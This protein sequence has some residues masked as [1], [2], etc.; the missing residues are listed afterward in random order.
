MK[1]TLNQVLI[2]CTVLIFCFGSAFTDI[3]LKSQGDSCALPGFFEKAVFSPDGEYVLATHV[4]GPMR[5]Y[6]TKTGELVQ[7]YLT[8]QPIHFIA[9]SPDG[10]YIAA[11]LKDRAVLLDVLTGKQLMS[12]M[13]N[14]ANPYENFEPSVFF[15][16]DGRFLLTG[17]SEGAALW[18]TVGGVQIHTYSGDMR[19]NNG[20]DEISVAA[21]Y[22]ITFDAEGFLLWNILTGKLIHKF[23][24]ISGGSASLSPDGKVIIIDDQRGLTVW[25]TQT[26]SEISALDSRDV[27]SRTWFFSP[28]SQYMVVSLWDH[29]IP[30]E[31]T[32]WQISPGKRLHNFSLPNNH[33]SPVVF[34]PDSKHLYLSSS[35]QPPET[36]NLYSIDVWSIPSIQLKRQI[37]LNTGIGASSFQFSADGTQW[38]VLQ[39][40]GQL[41]LREPNTGNEIMHYC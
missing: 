12:Y 13:R 11:G 21:Q 29:V 27:A 24:S 6:K 5:L 4:P 20:R 36:S 33:V 35:E 8:D 7:T 39:G 26:Y 25:S 9:F 1:N 31:L 10:K 41:Y 22:V 18:D 38:L 2:K 32:L 23:K 19:V 15:V 40:L 16:S 28:D 30:D 17:S 37:I 3:H 34:T 14:S